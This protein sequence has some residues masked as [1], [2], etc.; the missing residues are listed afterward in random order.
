MSS[1]TQNNGLA[2]NGAMT[3]LMIGG[4]KDKDVLDVVVVVDGAEIKPG[5]SLELLG[6]TFDPKFTMRLYLAKLTKEVR[7]RARRV[8]RLAQHLS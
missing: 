7:F 4:A 6:V 2:L 5:N 3:Q 8:A 1:F